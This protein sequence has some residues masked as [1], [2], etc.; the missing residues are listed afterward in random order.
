MTAESL[1]QVVGLTRLHNIF[2]ST[3]TANDMIVL[4]VNKY[5]IGIKKRRQVPAEEILKS[6]RATLREG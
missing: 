2:F 6:F 3:Q 5:I 1:R 4:A